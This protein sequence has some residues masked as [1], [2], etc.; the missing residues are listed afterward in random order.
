MKK[1]LHLVALIATIFFLS[2]GCQ[3]EWKPE[4]RVEAVTVTKTTVDDTTVLEGPSQNQK[5][6]LFLED[7]SK[8][9]FAK[10]A[11]PSQNVGSSPITLYVDADGEN[12]V[13]GS[14]WGIAGTFNCPKPTNNDL[15]SAKLDSIMKM[16]KEDFSPFLVNVVKT[17]TEYQSAPGLKMRI[18]VTKKTAQMQQSAILSGVPAVAYI[19]SLIWNDGTPCFVFINE[20]TG[21]ARY[22][23]IAES[24]SHELGHTFG[25]YH[26]KEPN[27]NFEYRFPSDDLLYGAIMGNPYQARF[28]RWIVGPSNSLPAGQLQ[29]DAEVIASIA[30]WKDNPYPNPPGNSGNPVL[31]SA[32]INSVLVQTSNQQVFYKGTTGNK[33]VTVTPSGNVKWRMKVLSSINDQ[34][35]AL[36][37]SDDYG[38]ISKQISG[39]KWIVVYTDSGLNG[40]ALSPAGGGFSIKAQ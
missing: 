31:S 36:Y 1:N 30:G 25:L 17:L 39:K 37:E 18:I 5:P 9:M 15:P 19:S 22:K 2:T 16:V 24:I 14:L 34:N 13:G 6:D 20:Y 7:V 29:D 35:A 28:T 21:S 40:Y 26:Q 8:T 32:V 12:N 3:K 11:L 23:M 27:T 4:S 33:T 10:A 38:K